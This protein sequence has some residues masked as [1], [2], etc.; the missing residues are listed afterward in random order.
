MNTGKGNVDTDN[1]IAPE[2]YCYVQGEVI[3]ETASAVKFWDGTEKDY[4]KVEVWIPKSQIEDQEE[5]TNDT[6][7]LLIPQWLAEEKGLV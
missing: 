2:G 7:E 6:V 1:R 3:Y 4:K 5:T